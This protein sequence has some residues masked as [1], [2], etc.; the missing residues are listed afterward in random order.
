MGRARKLLVKFSVLKNC[1]LV[2][3]SVFQD[4]FSIP[5]SPIWMDSSTTQQCRQLEQNMGGAQIVADKTGSRAYE[6][7]LTLRQKI[8]CVPKMFTKVFFPHILQRFT[9]NQIAKI[10]QQSSPQYEAT[11]VHKAKKGVLSTLL[12]LVYFL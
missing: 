3:Y 8:G 6:V 5:A 1:C 11:E 9:G 10:Y 2:A 7:I 4:C 12:L